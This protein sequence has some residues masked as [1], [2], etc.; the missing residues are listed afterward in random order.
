[1]SASIEE[2]KAAYSA[3]HTSSQTLYGPAQAPLPWKT[4]HALLLW[5]ALRKR[6]PQQAL[7]TFAALKGFAGKPKVSLPRIIITPFGLSQLA[8]AWRR[9]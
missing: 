1:M 8:K 5:T 7:Q 3:T 9:A 6:Q 4:L 2:R